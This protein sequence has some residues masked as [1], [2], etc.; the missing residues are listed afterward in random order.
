MRIKKITAYRKQAETRLENL[1]FQRAVRAAKERQTL[2]TEH[3]VLHNLIYQQISPGLR[4]QA[5]NRGKKVESM[6]QKHY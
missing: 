5:L 3:A 2:R 1:R 6:L 4:E